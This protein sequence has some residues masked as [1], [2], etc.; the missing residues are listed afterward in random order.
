M[1]LGF[2]DQLFFL[3]MNYTDLLAQYSLFQT[4]YELKHSPVLLEHALQLKARS[5][6][7]QGD[8]NLKRVVC[9]AA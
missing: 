2:R 7:P 9:M 8:K 6:W 4:L 1:Y 5:L 3:N